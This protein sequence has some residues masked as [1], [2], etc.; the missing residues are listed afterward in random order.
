MPNFAPET[1]EV[2][3][4]YAGGAVKTLHTYKTFK[5]AVSKCSKLSCNE[6]LKDSTDVVRYSVIHV[7]PNFKSLVYHAWV[8]D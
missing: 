3:V 1:F 6:R 2:A 8:R 7:H 4:F 5:S